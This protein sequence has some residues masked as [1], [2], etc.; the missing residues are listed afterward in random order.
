MKIWLLRKR[1]GVSNPDSGKTPS[2]VIDFPLAYWIARYEPTKIKQA[3][4]KSETG[5]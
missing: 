5:G 3:E 1:V 4:A 2:L